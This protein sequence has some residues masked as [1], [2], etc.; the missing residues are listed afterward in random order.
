MYWLIL[1][2]YTKAFVLVTGLSQIACNDLVEQINKDYHYSFVVAY[3]QEIIIE[4]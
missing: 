2:N 3:C 4:S 1:T